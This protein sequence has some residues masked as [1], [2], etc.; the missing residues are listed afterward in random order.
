M[1]NIF[2]EFLEKNNLGLDDAFNEL[3]L[4]E[5][6]TMTPG[7]P[8][9]IPEPNN[10][11]FYSINFK[12]E[13]KSYKFNLKNENNKRYLYITTA[14][15]TSINHDEQIKSLSSILDA[16]KARFG[17]ILAKK[18]TIVKNQSEVQLM[19]PLTGMEQKYKCFNITTIGNNAALLKNYL[20][21]YFSKNKNKMLDGDDAETEAEEQSMDT[22]DNSQSK[23]S[24][25][26][27]AQ[28]ETKGSTAKSGK[29]NGTLSLAREAR[30]ELKQEEIKEKI[31]KGMNDTKEKKELVKK[32]SALS[33]EQ[34]VAI[35]LTD[36]A[37]VSFIQRIQG[38][39]NIDPIPLGKKLNLSSKNGF[40]KLNAEMK[41]KKHS[42]YNMTPSEFNVTKANVDAFVKSYVLVQKALHNAGFTQPN[43]KIK[44]FLDA[45]AGT[46]SGRKSII[47][48]FFENHVNNHFTMKRIF[49]S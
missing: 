13:S 23:G 15:G 36:E 10:V 26:N 43:G 38:T 2:Y 35:A 29:K 7:M 40:K 21:S 5:F 39:N 22:I 16:G 4:F 1:N 37:V 47:N 33:N 45:W 17:K 19:N 28:S 41:T 12:Y 8:K 6:V 31:K 49:N 11:L 24:N 46:D 42:D 9:D 3:P 48:N 27:L 14:N 20:D 44:A 30:K 32:N 25:M 18:I 34:K